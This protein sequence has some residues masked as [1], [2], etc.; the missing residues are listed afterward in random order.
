MIFFAK[1]PG[2]PGRLLVVLFLVMTVSPAI[3]DDS[4]AM[5]RVDKFLA[6]TQTLSAEFAQ[7]LL[8]ESG[9][10]LTE[11]Q[12][13]MAIKRPGRFRWHY[14]TPEELLVL[15]DGKQVWSY[16]V[17]LENATMAAQDD[18]LSGNP[19]SLLAGDSNATE[20]FKVIK[21]WRAGNA[22]WIELAPRDAQHDFSAVRLGFA[23]DVLVSMELHDQ[24]GQTTRIVFDRVIQNNP[25]ADDLFVFT[26]PAGVDVITAGGFSP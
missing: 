21:T 13:T 22:D 16:D 20:A 24:L 25:L 1:Y 14:Q 8:D 18:T 15:G 19:A 11:S 7:T 2:H 3:A 4:E 23:N 17:E 9:R 26:V 12:G 5:S 10:V 6:S